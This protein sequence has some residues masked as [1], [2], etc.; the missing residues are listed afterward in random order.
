MVKRNWVF[1]LIQNVVN[2]IPIKYKT[3]GD[4]SVIYEMKN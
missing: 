4:K 2:N 1:F 3:G